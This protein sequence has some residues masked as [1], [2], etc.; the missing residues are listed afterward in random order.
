[1]STKPNWPNPLHTKVEVQLVR[2]PETLRPT[3]KLL[4]EL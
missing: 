2:V 3:E 1:M 4:H